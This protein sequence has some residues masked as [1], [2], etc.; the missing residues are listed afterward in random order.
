MPPEAEAECEVFAE[1]LW[2]VAAV[3]C[4]GASKHHLDLPMHACACVCVCVCVLVCVLVCV[5]VLGGTLDGW[6]YDI[7]GIT[8]TRSVNIP[9]IA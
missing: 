4:H 9:K 2:K 1:A 3:E 6:N 5:C 7:A 8:V